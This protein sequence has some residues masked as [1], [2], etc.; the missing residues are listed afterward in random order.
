MPPKYN[1]NYNGCVPRD[2]R[3]KVQDIVLVDKSA[4][5]E[6]VQRDIIN[7]VLEDPQGYLVKTKFMTRYLKYLRGVLNVVFHSL[8]PF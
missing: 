6:E 8:N 4:P 3:K 2:H 1:P 5:V 7:Q